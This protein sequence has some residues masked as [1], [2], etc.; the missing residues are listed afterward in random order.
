MQRQSGNIHLP[1]SVLQ[2]I[3]TKPFGSR[4]TVILIICC[5]QELAQCQGNVHL[6]ASLYSELSLSV[7]KLVLIWTL[8]TRTWCSHDL[9]SHDCMTAVLFHHE[10]CLAVRSTRVL[11][12]PNCL[13]LWS[14]QAQTRLTVVHHL[15]LEF[16]VFHVDEPGCSDLNRWCQSLSRDPLSCCSWKMFRRRLISRIL[17]VEAA[18]I[19]SW[20]G[21]CQKSFHSIT[22][23]IIVSLL[24][25]NSFQL[26][27]AFFI[28]LWWQNSSRRPVDGFKRQL[29]TKLGNLAFK[30]DFTVLTIIFKPYFFIYLI[31]LLLLVHC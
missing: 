2:T 25:I 7:C 17:C 21:V 12:Y 10:A 31:L 11:H 8:K 30:Q 26:V 15:Y 3:K 28:S 13:Q 14:F 27:F 19:C 18:F 23:D 9:Q 6:T 22:N 20:P 5:K 24:R 4:W 1:S 16:Y 29:K